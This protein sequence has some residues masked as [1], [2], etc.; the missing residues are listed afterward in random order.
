ME[1][2]ERR[3]ID[4]GYNCTGIYEWSKDIAKDRAKKERQ[5][6]YKARIVFKPSSKYTRGDHCGGYSVY[7]KPTAKKIKELAAQAVVKEQQKI[8]NLTAI[9]HYL[10]ART[11]EELVE[12]IKETQD[13]SESFLLYWARKKEIIK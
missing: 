9:K 10:L 7:T 11:G 8:A 2:A 3:A 6:G 12:L 1:K 13:N 5:K 4:D